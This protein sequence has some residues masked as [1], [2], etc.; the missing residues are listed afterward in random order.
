MTTHNVIIQWW[1]WRRHKDLALQ[2]SLE[3]GLRVICGT[4]YYCYLNFPVTPWSKY[5]EARTFDLQMAYEQN[6]S[7][8]MNPDPLVIG[9]STSLWTDWHV[10]EKMVDQ[11][12]SPGSMRWLNKYGTKEKDWILKIF[13]S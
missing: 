3:A 6:P 9:M 8:L 5:N 12:V 2:N 1:N 13:I 11:R 10:L 4:N 7:D